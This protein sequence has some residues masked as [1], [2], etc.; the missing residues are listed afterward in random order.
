MAKANQVFNLREIEQDLAF[1]Q[2]IKVGNMLFVSGVVSWDENAE[3]VG[4]GDMKAQVKKIYDELRDTLAAHGA[5]F[6][7]VVKETIYTVDLDALVEA[8]PIRAS[9]FENCVPPACT[10][11]QVDRLVHADLLIEIDVIAILA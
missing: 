1:S 11:V 4:V 2:A 8:A 5:T 7:H 10:G 9:F 3:P 6:A